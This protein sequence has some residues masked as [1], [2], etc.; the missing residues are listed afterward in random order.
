MSDQTRLGEQSR[1]RSTEK[2]R[3]LS[4]DD[5]DIPL[6]NDNENRERKL[7]HAAEEVA[8]NTVG[9]KPDRGAAVMTA[10]GEVYAAARIELLDE[11]Q[12]SHALELAVKQALSRGAGRIV[13]AVVLSNGDNVSICG[14]CRELVLSFGTTDTIIRGVADTDEAYAMSAGNLLPSRN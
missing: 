11:R 13:E 10:G 6:T 7:L 9:K 4:L 14:G 3:R 2:V 1:T 12:T 5:L 8:S